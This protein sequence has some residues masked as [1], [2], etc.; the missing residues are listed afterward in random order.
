MSTDTAHATDSAVHEHHG[1]TDLQYV[2]IFAILVVITGVEVALSYLVDDI[3]AFFLPLLLILM[4]VKFLMVVS[5][6]MHLKF[7]NR[8]FSVMFYTGLILAITVYGAF[9]FTFKFFSS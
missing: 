3:G 1:P 7:D 8:I 9:L 5:Y 4:A 2:G 6:F